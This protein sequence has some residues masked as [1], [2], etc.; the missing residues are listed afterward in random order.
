MG[1]ELEAD[2]GHQS[3]RAHRSKHRIGMSPDLVSIQ[4]LSAAVIV[5]GLTSCSRLS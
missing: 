3:R 5:D 1:D 2:N 4:E